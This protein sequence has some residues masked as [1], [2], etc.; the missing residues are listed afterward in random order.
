MKSSILLTV[1][2]N[3]LARSVSYVIVQDPGD[4]E[5]LSADAAD[6]AVLAD[7][8]DATIMYQYITVTGPY[9][10]TGNASETIAHEFLSVD[11]NDMSVV[12]VTEGYSPISNANPR[13]YLR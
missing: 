3:L 11:K 1:L 8:Q 13:K 7:W 10:Y 9:Y 12:V 6:N 2:A 5:D 4:S